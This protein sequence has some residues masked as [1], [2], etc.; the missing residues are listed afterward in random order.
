MSLY[1]YDPRYNLKTETTY[2]K[3]EKL[4]GISKNS[5]A[6]HKSQYLK[7]KKRY[8]LIDDKVTIGKIKELYTKEIFKN[9]I[10]KEIEG[11]EGKFLV[12]DYGRFKRIY[13]SSP[14]GKLLLP[15][16][17]NSRKNNRNKQYIKVKFKGVYKEYNIARL[18]AYHFVDIYYTRDSL[19]R[20]SKA[21]KYK[22][23]NYDE[24]TVYHKNEIVYDN[25]ACNLE[26]LDREDLLK[27]TAH[28]CK[29]K[30]TIVAKDASTG[31]IID[32][33]RSSR[34][35]AEKLYICKKAVLDSLNHKWKT[36]I[37]AGTYIF[38]YEDEAFA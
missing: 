19:I 8:Y 13:K 17:I 14:G 26:W 29:T 9:E 32:Y 28:K 2:D 34:E 38:E 7:I 22:Y 24:L 4:F 35:A 21:E 10:W 18:V 33:F 3:L 37:A 12:S 15:Y 11:S 1:L 16:F 25:N 27:K 5:L 30:G 6:S 31:E 23:Y 20:K 36:N